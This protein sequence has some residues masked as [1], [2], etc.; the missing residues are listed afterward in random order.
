VIGEHIG[1]ALRHRENG[2]V[3]SLFRP[4]WLYETAQEKSKAFFPGCQPSALSHWHGQGK[5]RSV[6]TSLPPPS[7]L[8]TKKHPDRV[9]WKL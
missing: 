1:S 5:K 6:L 8:R 9:G 7:S 3:H 4:G 2:L